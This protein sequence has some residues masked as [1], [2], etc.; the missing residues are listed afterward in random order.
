M[1]YRKF[2]ETLSLEGK[3]ALI[4]GASSGIGFEMTKMFARKG[5]KIAT[6][7]LKN[8]ILLNEY[9]SQYN[10][11]LSIEG[12]VAILEDVQAAVKQVK[13][14]FN[15]IDIL[16]NCAGVGFLEPS[17]ESTKKI[18][19]LTISVNLTGTVNMCIETAKIMIE[20]NKGSIINIA[21]Q[22]GIVAIENHLA[23]GITKA[24]IIQA[25]KQFALEWGKYN[26]RSNAISPTIILTPMGEMNWNN[27]KGKAVM[28]TIPLKRFGYPEEVA[29]AA[30]FLASDASRL[31]NGANLVIDGGYTI[32]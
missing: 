10:E 20:Q 15:Y 12:D 32:V 16:V 3:V 2:D 30:L 31:F 7:D 5:A 14:K 9:I 4:T 21:S 25:T 29:A 19:D 22:A 8:S 11:Y 1:D 28:E 27:E 17:I 6:L 26:V 23:Y 13:E 18:W 24:G